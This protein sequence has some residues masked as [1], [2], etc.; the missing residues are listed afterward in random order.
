[1]DTVSDK[2]QGTQDA[3]HRWGL[4]GAPRDGLTLPKCGDRAG[5]FYVLSTIVGR[6]AIKLQP[7]DLYFLKP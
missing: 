4:A 1:M 5:Q 7:Q 3:Q 6:K 2:R